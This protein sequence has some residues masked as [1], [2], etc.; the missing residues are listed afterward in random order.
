MSPSEHL[1]QSPLM[2]STSLVYVRVQMHPTLAD[3]QNPGQRGLGERHC[4]FFH[5]EVF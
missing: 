2:L 1:P 5:M 3:R 4:H